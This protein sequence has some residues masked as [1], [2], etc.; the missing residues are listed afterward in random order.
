M[1]R[2][3]P[4]SKKN[5]REMSSFIGNGLLFD[6]LNNQLDEDRKKAVENYLRFSRDAQLELEKIQSA[7]LF[8]E[9]L[10]NLSVQ[11]QVIK[12]IESQQN[13]IQV[14]LHKTKL[15]QLPAGIRWGIEAIGAMMII[16]ILLIFTPW[17]KIIQKSLNN[18]QD[19]IILAE[20]NVNKENNGTSGPEV[21]GDFADEELT[22]TKKDLQQTADSNIHSKTETIANETQTNQPSK[23]KD[24]V[25]INDLPNKNKVESLDSNSKDTVQKHEGFL[26]R[27]DLKITNISASGAKITAKIN[28]L[29]GRKAGEVNLGWKKG[30]SSLYYHFTIPETKYKDLLAFLNSYGKINLVKERHPRIMPEGIVR[31]ILTVDEAQK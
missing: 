29:G 3:I 20:I 2:Q 8:A 4:L 21:K 25:V 11:E 12:K 9:S 27:G 7:I 10:K 18:Q 26:F 13:Y 23:E 24:K 14:F 19:S 5:Q 28:E 30:Q 15:K 22:N 16:L 17:Q 31:V 1:I 6:Y